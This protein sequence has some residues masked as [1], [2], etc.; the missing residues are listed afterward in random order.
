MIAA[1][2]VALV[3]GCGGI[4]ASS[5]RP[6]PEGWTLLAPSP[7]EPRGGHTAVWT[8][9][10]MIV[11][12]GSRAGSTPLKGGSPDGGGFSHEPNTGEYTPIYEK[13]FADGADYDP[14]SDTW[15]RLPPA[16]LD[17]RSGH[18]AVWTGKEMI[19][20]G[21]F[22]GRAGRLT[23]GAAYDRRAGRWRKIARSPFD[24]AP[25][26]TAVWTGREL[27]LWGGFDHR[28][29][30]AAV[31][32]AYDPSD[33][34]WRLLPASPL[35]PRQ[36]QVRPAHE[37]MAAPCAGADCRAVLAHGNLERLRSSRLGWEDRSIRGG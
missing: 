5:P 16:P 9:R 2:V 21:G 20:W 33:D 11:W 28:P 4:Q 14:R 23:D 32:A 6:A 25:D 17:P 3:A 1:L 19:V 18:A 36:W 26:V 29:D 8:G 24:D 27:I 15:R 34:A 31:G 22:G 35:S 13:H 12:G 7:L 37:R 10:A 30:R